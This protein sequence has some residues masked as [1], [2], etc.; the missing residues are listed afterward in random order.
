VKVDLYGLIETRWNAFL[1]DYPTDNEE[2]SRRSI[3]FVHGAKDYAVDAG[4][5][6]ARAGYGVS[7]PFRATLWA[8]GIGSP[9]SDWRAF[10]ASNEA[11]RNAS[12]RWMQR[13]LPAD[14]SSS[15]YQSARSFSRNALDVGS[16]AL[17]GVGLVKGAMSLGFR[18][19]MST[20]AA[21]GS[22]QIQQSLK[23]YSREL[24]ESEELLN[25]TAHLRF[26]EA[27]WRFP[28]NPSELLRELQRDRKGI[29][30]TSDNLRIRPEKHSIKPGDIFSPRHHG[31]HYHIETRRD[32][33]KSWNNKNIEIVK[34]KNYK[35]GSG[36][37][38]LPDEYF[39][40]IE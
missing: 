38:F 16:M 28:K 40:G 31:Q 9:S 33:N 30:Y 19:Y 17:G 37:G 24:K 39:P 34:P 7:I 26:K 35:E 6:A 18:G 4:I 10:Q 23:L 15:A 29:I 8:I 20:R 21:F 14:M 27:T 5:F 1:K 22:R 3:G 13:V 11:F 32:P 12:D 25:Y 36:S 2:I